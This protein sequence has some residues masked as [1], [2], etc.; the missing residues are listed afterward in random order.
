MKSSYK[1]EKCGEEFDSQ[2]ECLDHEAKCDSNN[3]LEKRVAVLEKRLAELAAKMAL[4]E[5]APR[6]V[7]PIVVPASPQNPY[8]Y[9]STP[10][11]PPVW[12]QV[13]PNASSKSDNQGIR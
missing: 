4:F 7:Q 10:V 2:G 11:F 13:E 8:P 9:P 6:P 5:S 3:A 12:C 1:C